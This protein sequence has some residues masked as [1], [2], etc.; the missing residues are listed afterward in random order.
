M[1]AEMLALRSLMGKGADTDTLREVIA[2]AA[3]RLMELD[4]QGPTDAPLTA[5]RWFSA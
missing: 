3:E 5:S 2:P 1:I 4:V